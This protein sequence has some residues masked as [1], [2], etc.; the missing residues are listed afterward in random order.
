MEPCIIRTGGL[1]EPIENTR[2]IAEI[3]NHIGT[4]DLATVNLRNGFTMFLDDLG[5][6]KGLPF[7]AEGTRLYHSICRPGT[8]HQILGDVVLVRTW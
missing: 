4:R 2:S 6:Q 7:N 5:H 3:S 8:T 1:R